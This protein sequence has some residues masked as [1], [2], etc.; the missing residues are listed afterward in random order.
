M[1]S[2]SRTPRRR[3]GSK[4]KGHDDEGSS[5]TAAL[6][7]DD[8][9]AICQVIVETMFP[10]TQT[11][12]R[13]YLKTALQARRLEC[14]FGIG[15]DNKEAVVK[16]VHGK[17]DGVQVRVPSTST[18]ALLQLM[19]KFDHGFFIVNSNSKDTF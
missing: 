17:I 9:T 8:T 18:S 1:T 3:N 16:F 10:A 15:I 7:Q 4:T 2:R 12:S 13:E 14:I 5:P 19:D 11:K 6:L